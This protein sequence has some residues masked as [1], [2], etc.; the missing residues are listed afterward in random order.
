MFGF[1]KKKQRLAEANEAAEAAKRTGAETDAL[2]T[3][4]TQPIDE[5]TSEVKA[6]DLAQTP[7]PARKLRRA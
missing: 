1:G 5:A 4:R 7:R 6:A 3:A 2:A